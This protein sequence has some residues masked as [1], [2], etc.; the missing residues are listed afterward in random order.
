VEWR[1][2]H[3]EELHELYCYRNIVRVIKLR[4]MRYVARM[5]ERRGAHK[6][7]VRKPDGMVSLGRPRRRWKND[8]KMDVKGLGLEG[9]GFILVSLADEA[10][11]NDRVS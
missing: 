5:G 7:L 10:V 4:R 3:T 11:I 9:V 6:V 2:L 8:A 1:K